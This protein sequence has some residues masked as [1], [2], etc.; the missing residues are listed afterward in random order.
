MSVALDVA[1]PEGLPQD[2]PIRRVLDGEEAY[3][4]DNDDANLGEAL[5]RSCAAVRLDTSHP[6]SEAQT[7]PGEPR[8]TRTYDPETVCLWWARK[9][10]DR[11]QT[12]G[13]YLGRNEKTTILVKLRPDGRA[14]GAGGLN[15]DIF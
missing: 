14:F 15:G 4:N 1:V 7:E 6:P 9:N 5:P 10:M 2:H 3:D 12:L 11:E 13:D 8:P